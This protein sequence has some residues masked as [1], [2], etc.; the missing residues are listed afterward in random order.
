MIVEFAKKY[1]VQ[2]FVITHSKECLEAVLHLVR[3]D[4]SSFRLL[5]TDR[6]A[7]NFSV[8]KFSGAEF[9]AAISEDVEVR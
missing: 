7:G 3:D 4:E 2:L 6:R 8:H 1:E 5:K 9:E